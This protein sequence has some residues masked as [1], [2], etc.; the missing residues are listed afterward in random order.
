[1]GVVSKKLGTMASNVHWFHEDL[2]APQG[3]KSLANGEGRDLNSRFEKIESTKDELLDETESF[4]ANITKELNVSKNIF[5]VTSSL[6]VIMM[7]FEFFTNSKRTIINNAREF[8]AAKELADNGGVQSVKLGEIIRVALEQNNLKNCAKLFNNFY[9]NNTFEKSIKNKGTNALDALITPGTIVAERASKEKIEKI[10]N[11]DSIGIMADNVITETSNAINLEQITNT[12]IDLLSDKLFSKGVQIEC[13]IDSS[14]YLAGSEEVL[15][16]VIYHS[17]IFSVNHTGHSIES[18]KIISV[19]ALKLGD[20]VAI[21]ITASGNG[22]NNE[23]L[24][25]RIGLESQKTELDI[26]LQIAQSLVLEA[27][28]KT[29]LDNRLSQNGNVNGTR[30]KL[31][32]KG[33]EAH[34]TAKLMDIKKGSKKEILAQ[35]NA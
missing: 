22:F 12:A 21:D 25:Q 5:Y 4:K 35:L 19:N 11:D 7:I 3:V 6:L 17:L 31:I 18:N 34:K 10:W 33:S 2:I 1:M 28:G 8:E 26:D 20:V 27:G 9:V 32:L 16:Q 15:E 23:M 30:I 14:I 29:Q 24:K 13:N